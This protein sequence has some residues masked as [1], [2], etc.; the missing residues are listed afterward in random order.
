MGISIVVPAYNSG[1]YLAATIQSVLAQTRQ[2]WELVVV[3]DGSTDQT[4]TIAQTYARLDNR[5]RVVDQANAG[6]SRARNRG[7]AE[8]RTDYEYCLFLDSDDLLEP[9][10]LEILL[11]AL[12]RDPEAVAAYGLLQYIDRGGKPV[13]VDGAYTAP[14][15]RRGVQGKRL[16]LCSVSAPTTF[17]VLA[18][19]NC[20]PTSGMMMRRAQKD[21]AGDFD[22]SFKVF[23]DWD[24]WLRLSR[25]GHI[26]FVNRIIYG[27]R[28]HGGNTSSDRALMRETEFAVRKK[29]YTSPDLNEREKRMILLGYRY[30]QLYRARL[31]LL[32]FA[33]NVSGKRWVDAITQF[34]AAMRHILCAIKGDL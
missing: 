5:I 19:A 26:A 15:R 21:I 2:D 27:Y 9:E 29:I 34:R 10:A 25:L 14:R 6:I 11:D 20:I 31:G 32:Y 12:D 23:E 17:A 22:P 13:E 8:T 24:L 16:K 33:R 7:L 18:Y 3:N 4:G 30:N 28:Q 1:K